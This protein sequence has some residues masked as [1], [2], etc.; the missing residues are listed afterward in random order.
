MYLR[1]MS[2]EKTF[3]KVHF[4]GEH[5]PVIGRELLMD[6]ETWCV[7]FHGVARS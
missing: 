7:A 1:C 4:E 5:K 6:R 3:E 2:E